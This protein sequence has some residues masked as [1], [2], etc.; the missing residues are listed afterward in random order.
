M[1]RFAAEVDLVKRLYNASWERNWGFV[2]MTGREIEHHA[3]QLE[4][5]VVPELDSRES[6]ART[7]RRRG[8]TQAGSDRWSR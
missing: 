5:V 8:A 7:S 2:P 3:R 1:P 4:P 6:R